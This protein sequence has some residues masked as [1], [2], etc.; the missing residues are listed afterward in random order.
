MSIE[1]RV[2][3][4]EQVLSPTTPDL[5]MAV[6]MVGET[7]TGWT[8]AGH[9][10]DRLPGETDSDFKDR[11]LCQL[12]KIFPGPVECCQALGELLPG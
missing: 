5:L 1:R 4:L 2:K 8:G 7:P 11:A 10:L 6:F 12:A 9:T 3:A